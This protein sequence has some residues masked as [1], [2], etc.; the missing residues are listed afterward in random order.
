[1]S[2]FSSEPHM[3]CEFF[4]QRENIFSKVECFHGYEIFGKNYERIEN[5]YKGI[6]YPCEGGYIDFLLERKS[7]LLI[8]EL[9]HNTK[10]PAG[11]LCQIYL[12]FLKLKKEFKDKEISIVVIYGDSPCKSDINELK[13]AMLAKGREIKYIKRDENLELEKQIKKEYPFPEYKLEKEGGFFLIKH[14]NELLVI[15]E[16]SGYKGFGQ[17]SWLIG[18]KIEDEPRY[19]V[20]GVIFGKKN[21]N[22]KRLIKAIDEFN[23]NKD[24]IA[25]I[26][27]EFRI[28]YNNTIKFDL[29]PTK[30]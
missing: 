11:V 19:K 4:A 3:Q 14:K 24:I 29:I 21:K 25:N 16:N 23:K 28:W 22:E 1:M 27:V 17:I 8:V 5:Y 12:Y 30:P 2:K 6:E 20:S 26:D 7:K 9:K 13:L 18:K 10:Q 15:C